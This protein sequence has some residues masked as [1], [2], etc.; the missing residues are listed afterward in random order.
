MVREQANIA[1]DA[2]IGANKQAN[3]LKGFLVSMILF[4]FE[5]L[6][7]ST[8]FAIGKQYEESNVECPELTWVSEDMEHKDDE[9][10]RRQE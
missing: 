6:G 2:V 7:L 3:L 4:N 1:V 5:R 9:V 8:N 10:M